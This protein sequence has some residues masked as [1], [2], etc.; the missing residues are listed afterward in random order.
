MDDKCLPGDARVLKL[1]NGEEFMVTHVGVATDETLGIKYLEYK[2]PRQLVADPSTGRLV[3]FTLPYLY[4]DS[5]KSCF[6]CALT[7]VVSYMKMNEKTKTTYLADVNNIATATPEEV[8]N[9][10]NAPKLILS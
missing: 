6:R 3:I 10:K 1:L 7:A 9:V 8:N 5:Y 2:D 4:H